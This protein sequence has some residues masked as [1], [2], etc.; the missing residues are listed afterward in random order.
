MYKDEFGFLD[1]SNQLDFRLGIIKP[2]HNYEQNTLSI[3]KY[4]N[5]D[6]FI[7]PPP[8]DDYEY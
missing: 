4:L 6:G 3:R 2:H 7:Y 5:R 8:M 1:Y